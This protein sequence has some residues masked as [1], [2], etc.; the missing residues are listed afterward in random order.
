MLNEAENY[1]EPGAV[2]KSSKMDPMFVET[3][4]QS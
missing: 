3:S 1:K 2:E 4:Q